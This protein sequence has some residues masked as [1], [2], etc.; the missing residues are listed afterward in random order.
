M[1]V[2]KKLKTYNSRNKLTY[3][4]KKLTNGVAYYYKIQ[5]YKNYK[6]KKLLGEM[7]PFE[8]YC[9]YFTYKNESYESRCKRIFGKKYYKKYK[10]LDET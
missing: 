5:A 9:D 2:I 8:K 10:K 6:G 4:H 7:S 1:E 3:T